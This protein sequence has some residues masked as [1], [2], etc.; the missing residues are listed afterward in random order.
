MK[1]LFVDAI[2]SFTNDIMVDL[3][4][5]HEVVVTPNKFL[6]NPMPI[7]EGEKPDIVWFE[8]A[9]E[10]LVTASQYKK[11]NYKVINR[12]HSY[13][14]FHPTH[15]HTI[16][17]D[18]VDDIIFVA[19]HTK[20]M[21]ECNVQLDKTKT[22]VIH[23]GVRLDKFVFDKDKKYG[24]KLA[25]VGDLNHKKNI[26]FLLQCYDK[27][28]G[29]YEDYSL[30][31]AGDW[32][33]LRIQLA[34]TDFINKRQL[35]DITFYGR[36]DDIPTW[37][38][39]KDYIFS[40]SPFESFHYSAM[41]GIACGCLPLIYH[42]YGAEKLY[43]RNSLFLNIDECLGIINMIKD[44]DHMEIKAK[45]NLED[46]KKRFSFEVQMKQI[47]KLINSYEEG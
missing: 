46:V 20:T 9:N 43:P 44:R 26:P 1:I 11:G 18:Y 4:K 10:P 12:L 17:W 37:L 16:K 33:D 14:L 23:N 41:E 36:V 24:T 6:T 5:E 30:H 28:K 39:D 2:Q 32:K 34:C 45:K 21:F 47:K 38:K 42:W 22:H 7:I 15:I 8:W 31:I 3:G 40:T 13:E 35:K 29:Y 19:D 25:F 27:I